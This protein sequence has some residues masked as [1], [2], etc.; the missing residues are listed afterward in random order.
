MQNIPKK[1]HYCWFGRGKKSRLIRKCVKS[2]TRFCPDWEIIEW[3]EDNV[4][5]EG[6]QWTKEAYEAHK[7]AFVSDYFRLKALYDCGGIYLDTDV[8]LVKPLDEY[9]DNTFFCGFETDTAVATCVIGATKGNKVVK[10][11]MQWYC[12]RPYILDGKPNMEPNVAFVTDRLTAL[13]LTIDGK[14][15]SANGVTI[16]PQ[17]YFCP[18]YAEAVGGKLTNETAAIHYFDSSWRSPEGRKAMKR[19]QKHSMPMYQR[20]E[21]W[22]YLPNLLI[23]KV[24]GDKHTERLKEKIAKKY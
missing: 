1:I 14:H 9:L 6:L 18:R 16:Y 2:W 5:I 3:N 20:L 13:G 8:E 15:Q 24:L 4:D 21:R 10:D 7:Y 12:D 19:A 22:R 17:H 23:R 11:L